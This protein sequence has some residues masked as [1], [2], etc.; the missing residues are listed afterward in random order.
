MPLAAVLAGLRRGSGGRRIEVRM[1]LDHSR[2]RP[3]A[4]AQ[5]T[6]RLAAA[7]PDVVV[8][9]G[10]AGDEAA[11]LAPYARA[12]GA[13]PPRPACTWCTTP[14]RPRGP[15]S[16]RE[17][18]GVGRAERIGHG[19]RSLEDP[20]LVAELRDRRVPLEVCPSSNVAARAGALAR[21]APAAPRW[22][23]PGWRSPLNT[24]I[25]SVTGRTAVGTST[26]RFGRRS[27]ATD[28]ELAAVRARRGRRQLRPAGA[29]GGAPP[30]HHRLAHRLTT[31]GRPG[32]VGRS[33]IGG[34]GAGRVSAGR[35][36]TVGLGSR[37]GRWR[38]VVRR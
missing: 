15:A 25:P 3:P 12:D 2:R 22:S 6:V 21:R 14:G 4:W 26:P 7:H 11:P 34:G 24:D 35:A 8:G 31:P 36:G 9:F 32:V 33:W 18:L 29:Q 16:V 38:R 23:R 30:R 28:A 13:W 1:L 19:I 20:A 37:R 17:A 10:M 27:A 5:E